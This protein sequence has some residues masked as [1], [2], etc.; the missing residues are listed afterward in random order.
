MIYLHEMGRLFSR[1][2]ENTVEP[3]SMQQH[4]KTVLRKAGIPDL[5]FH[6]LRQTFATKCIQRGFDIKSH[7]MILGHSD[8]N[9]TMNVYV[10]PS[11]E[12]LQDMMSLID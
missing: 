9:I 1:D 12:R 3:C 8:V 10:H 4:F 2:A 11:F 6:V 7:S 5:N